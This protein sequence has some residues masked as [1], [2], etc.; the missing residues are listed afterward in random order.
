M[1]D[2]R[3]RWQPRWR[4][5]LLWGM[6]LALVLAL[7]SLVSPFRLNLLGRYLSLAI[8]GVMMAYGLRNLA[9]AAAGLRLMRHLLKPHGRGVALDFNRPTHPLWAQAQRSYLQRVVVPV[10]RLLDL[11]AEYTYLE[12]SIATFATG[13]QQETLAR[14]AGFAV[15]RHHPVAGGLMGLLELGLT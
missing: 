5:V 8:V 2:T 11:E 14:Q 10:A 4:Q 13:A 12:R 6:G 3:S 7:P 15:A 9:S 1:A